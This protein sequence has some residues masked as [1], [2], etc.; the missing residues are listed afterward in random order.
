MNGTILHCLATEESGK[1][2]GIIDIYKHYSSFCCIFICGC[3]RRFV[4]AKKLG[5]WL[6]LMQGHVSCF[7]G[8]SA[9]SFKDIID[10]LYF[11]RR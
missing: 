2:W 7:S 4:C 11:E 5:L 10:F 8:E 1:T 6:G 9:A 3:E